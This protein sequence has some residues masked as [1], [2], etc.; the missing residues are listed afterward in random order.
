MA[1][2]KKPA[3]SKID[4]TAPRNKTPKQPMNLPGKSGGKKPA[5]S[6]REKSGLALSKTIQANQ[7]DRL[8]E[9]KGTKGLVNTALLAASVTP[10]GRGVRAS[11]VSK[12]VKKSG[13]PA[14][15]GDAAYV[16]ASKGLPGAT[17]MGGKISK[18]WTPAG[19]T[20]RSTIV[21]SPA[22][23][24][25]RIAN[26]YS[27]AARIGNRTEA[28]TKTKMIAETTK[29]V[30]KAAKVISE[31]SATALVATNKPKKKKK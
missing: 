30:N 20:I 18:T 22:Q 8:R 31:G 14:R 6:T 5:L 16:A 4:P 29:V 11:I 1:A 28:A 23:Q 10:V 7:K 26:L 15:A 13:I 3:Q 25:A 17:G 21:G 19:K 27:N 2:K 9:F 12:I 24:E